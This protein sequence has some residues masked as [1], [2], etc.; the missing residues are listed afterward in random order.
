[1]L[2]ARRRAGRVG[3]PAACYC[4]PVASSLPEMGS[5]SSDQLLELQRL[6]SVVRSFGEGVGQ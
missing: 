1:M 6:Q 4:D 2:W 5:S 3:Q